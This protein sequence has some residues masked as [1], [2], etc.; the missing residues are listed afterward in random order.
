[1]LSDIS[2]QYGQVCNMSEQLCV[3]KL[4]VKLSAILCVIIVSAD[5]RMVLLVV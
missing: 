3:D 2:R 4:L 5:N 1:M